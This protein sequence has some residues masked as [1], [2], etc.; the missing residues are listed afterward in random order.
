MGSTE[1]TQFISPIFKFQSISQTLPFYSYD[2]QLNKWKSCKSSNSA[3]LS[4]IRIATWNVWFDPYYYEERFNEIMRVLKESKADIICLQEGWEDYDCIYQLD[5]FTNFCQQD[6][7]CGLGK[8]RV[9]TFGYHWMYCESV[10]SD[11]SIK[12]TN[13]SSHYSYTSD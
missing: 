10:W 5:S 8:T 7:Q 11:H 13:S 1:T 12:N 9:S 4:N 2:K 3:Q 6:Y